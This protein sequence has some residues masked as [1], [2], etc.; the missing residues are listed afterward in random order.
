MRQWQKVQEVLRVKRDTVLA[1]S[2]GLDSTTLLYLLHSQGCRLRALG[3]H[4]GQRHQKELRAAESLCRELQVEFRRVDLSSLSPL[5]AGSALTSGEVEVPEGH[6]TDESMGQTVVPNRNMLLLSV[7]IAW[8]VSAGS[9]S[10][11]YAA[12]AGDH[13]V[14]SDCRP[15]FVEAMDQAAA[16]CSYA[17]VRILRPF[18]HKTKA[19]IVGL[20]HEL[21]V[22]FE[23]T[24]SCYQGRDLHCGRCGTCSERAEAFLLAGVPDP[25]VYRSSPPILGE[26]P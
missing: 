3:V 26:R 19:E 18:I 10:V 22:P 25:T 17:P 12:H 24:W 23:R 8:A 16:L 20:G 14:Y 1:Y 11:A 4:Y 7:A 2:G 21:G 15:E 5:L 9:G 6:Y 13:A